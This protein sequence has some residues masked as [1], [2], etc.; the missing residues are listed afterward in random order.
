M[1]AVTPARVIVDYGVAPHHQ[2]CWLPE[3]YSGSDSIYCLLAKFARLNVLTIRDLCELFVER[4]PVVG[5]RSPQGRPHYPVVD[6]RFSNGLRVGRLANV[7]KLDAAKVQLAFVEAVAPNAANRAA[8]YL[9]WC[10]A[11]AKNGFHS[12]VFQLDFVCACPLHSIALLHRCRGCASPLPYRLHAPLGGDLFYC[13]R[14]DADL[15]PI[16]QRPQRGLALAGRAATVLADHVALVRF[17]AQIP[18]LIDSCRASLESPHM[19]LM[20]GRADKGRRTALFQQFVGDV[21]TSVAARAGRCRQPQLQMLVPISVYLDSRASGSSKSATQISTPLPSESVARATDRK[22]IEAVSIYKSVRRHLWQHHLCGHQDCARYAMK[23]LW[24]DLDGEK[25]P[26]FCGAA[27]AFIRWRM[28]W[29]GRCV[30]SRLA[31]RSGSKAVPYGL[32][33]WISGDAPIPSI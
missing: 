2:W 11:C 10:P 23:S 26:A 27:Q 30:P 31:E 19:P 5:T 14:C 25:T 22:L 32:L 9:K 24:W 18:T 29:E 21:L 7:L 8:T 13:A 1:V 16:L 6:L 17:T 33:G 15:A 12:A 28:Q 20:L 4:N 3:W